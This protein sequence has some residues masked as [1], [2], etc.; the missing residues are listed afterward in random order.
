M[1]FIRG[2]LSTKLKLQPS[3]FYPSDLGDFESLDHEP[4]KLVRLIRFM[5]LDVD[6]LE[7]VKIHTELSW[8]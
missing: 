6:D 3:A 2:I 5:I 7:Y 4:T 1:F 8:F